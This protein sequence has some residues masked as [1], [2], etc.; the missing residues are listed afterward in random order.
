MKNQSIYLWL[1]IVILTMISSCDCEREYTVFGTITDENYVPLSGV[2]V[3]SYSTGTIT[4]GADGSYI[5]VDR[6]FGPFTGNTLTFT[7]QGYQ[8]V[9]SEPFTAVEAD[10]CGST[11]LRRDVI[12]PL[13]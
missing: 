11:T 10:F 4:S 7:K 1:F 2:Q 8:T 12:L 5:F 3:I 6:T 9:E 13:M